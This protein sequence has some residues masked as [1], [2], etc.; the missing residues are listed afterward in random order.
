M[1]LVRL[2]A[3]AALAALLVPTAASSSA[4]ET[5]PYK[6]V[7]TA[8]PEDPL[9]PQVRV[10]GTCLATHLGRE[11]FV[12]SHTLVPTGPPDANGMLPLA[13]VA[14][15]GTH[16]AANGDE[17][18]SVYAGSGRVDLATGRI[19]FEFEGTYTGGTGRFANA[20]GATRIRGV[21]ENGVA[22]F[23]EDGSITY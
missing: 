17:L 15:Q 20:A 14:G 21:V 8:V 16:V 6:A 4:Q 13:I 3:T 1:M 18:R 9:S 11:A 10:T 2:V 12:A 7:C 19:E 5:R 23:S 22:R